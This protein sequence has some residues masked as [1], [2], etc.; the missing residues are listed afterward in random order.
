MNDRY[1]KHELTGTG[2]SFIP[3]CGHLMLD[4]RFGNS[5][6]NTHKVD[7]RSRTNEIEP[8]FARSR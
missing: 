7:Y 5:L 6:N 2:A 1:C 3:K 4:Q 8:N